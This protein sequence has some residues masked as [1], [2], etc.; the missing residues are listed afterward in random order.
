MASEHLDKTCHIGNVA[1]VLVSLCIWWQQHSTVL[2]GDVA[3]CIRLH[4]LFNRHACWMICRDA[5]LVIRL[6]LGS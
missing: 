2:M 3:G 6:P 5:H 1:L 4:R